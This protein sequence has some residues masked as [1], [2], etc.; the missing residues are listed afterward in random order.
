V[1]ITVNLNICDAHGECVVEAPTIF[2]LGDDDE[3]V[4]VLQDEVEG[5]DLEKA[6]QRAMESCP[7]AAITL[8][9]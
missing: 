4:T 7:V 2:D 3:H 8:D 5:A 1:K 9:G 6:A